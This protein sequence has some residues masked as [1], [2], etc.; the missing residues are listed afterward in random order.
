MLT[1]KVDCFTNY[2]T[3]FVL[4]GENIYGYKAKYKRRNSDKI[5]FVLFKKRI[6]G[7][8]QYIFDILAEMKLLSEYKKGPYI[9]TIANGSDGYLMNGYA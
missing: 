3:P 8:S 2:I 4:N 6:Y 1:K 9:G 7:D 5:K